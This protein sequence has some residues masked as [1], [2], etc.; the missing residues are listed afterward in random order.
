MWW[1]GLASSLPDGAGNLVCD[2]DGVIYLGRRAVAGSAEVL[3]DL[4]QVGWNIL[5]CTNNSSR[6][7]AEVAERLARVGGFE[8]EA[9]SVLTSAQAAAALLAADQPPTFVLGGRGVTVALEEAG[10]PVVETAAGAEAVVVGLAVDLTYAW[11]REAVTAVHNGARL[12][13]TNLDP[14][15]PTEQGPWPGGGAIVAAVEVASGRTAEPAGKPFAP[16]RRLIERHLT[17]GPVWVVGDRPDTDVALARGDP[18]WKAALVLTGVTDSPAGVEPAP[19]LVA[20][21]LAAVGRFLLG[22]MQ[23]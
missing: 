16:M 13:A 22:R 5:F 18:P 9:E 8:A 6:P 21:D 12:I 19:D 17:P 11:L 3:R 14:T 4:Q 15:F 2:I 10:V 23:A 20:P 1:R 7:P